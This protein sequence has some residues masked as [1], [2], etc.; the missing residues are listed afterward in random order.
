ML[1]Y[2]FM[3]L[4]AAAAAVNLVGAKKGNAVLSNVSKP[5]LLPC[6]CLYCLSVTYPEP[7]ILLICA[8][9]ACWLG[10]VLLMLKSEIWFAA[11]GVSFFAGHV[12]LIF[13]FSNRLGSQY[14]VFGA[15]TG[16]SLIYAAAACTVIFM[17]RKKAPK[18]MLI[19]M[20]LYL[21]CNGVMNAFALL[22]L[23]RSDGMAM[24][25]PGPE[26]I[27]QTVCCAVSFIGA[28]LFFISDC[29]LFL[30]KYGGEKP[31]FYKSDF[32]VML[33]YISGVCLIT[34]GLAPVWG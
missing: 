16:F 22:C 10:D 33:T 19:P 34:L 2:V 32:F 4:F 8:L 30:Q 11:G 3:L 7:D 24:H 31:R 26:E 14:G 9:A 1:P 6:L 25:T 23:I 5:A 20:L 17:T 29:A 18:I 27:R 12:L 13:V 15:V 21:L 28:L